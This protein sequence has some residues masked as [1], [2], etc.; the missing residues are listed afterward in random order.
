ML[1]FCVLASVREM[2]NFQNQS[3]SFNNPLPINTYK[4]NG[5]FPSL[6]DF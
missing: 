1:F 4:N 6:G 5:D 3:H 2:P